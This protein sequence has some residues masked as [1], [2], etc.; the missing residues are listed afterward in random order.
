MGTKFKRKL[1]MLIA[2]ALV[3]AFVSTGVG[4]GFS[5]YGLF[6]LKRIFLSRI[7][8]GSPHYKQLEDARKALL[9]DTFQGYQQA[10]DGAAELLRI[11]PYAEAQALWCQAVFYLSRKYAT[12][13]ASDL[14]RAAAL[15]ENIV[16]L[17]DKNTDVVKASAC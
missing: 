13:S 14:A 7:S 11:K 17:G 10:R 12:S 15:V 1:P 5:R 3:L 16:L 9:A 6:A 2:A 4:L 8:E